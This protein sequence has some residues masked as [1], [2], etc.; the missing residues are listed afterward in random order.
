MFLCRE[1]ELKTLNR[2]YRNRT[3]ECIVIYGRRRVGKTALINEFVADKPTVYFPALKA[4]AQ[5][6]LEA[7]SKA[8]YAYTNPNALQAPV[9]GSFD[10]AFSEIT[11][12]AKQERIV[13]VIDE[14]PYL[15]KADDSIP[16]R[17]QHLL[18]RDWSES[19]IFLILCGSSMS[20]M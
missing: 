7:L 17:L 11:R 14:F 18:D 19:G 9:F 1:S 12:L 3:P 2:R 16:S 20:F 10:A 4:T 15:A 13:F 5:E 6:N 8:I